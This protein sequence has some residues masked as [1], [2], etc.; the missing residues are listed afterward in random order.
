M[1]RRRGPDMSRAS[2]TWPLWS[3]E[4]TLVVT[5]PAKLDPAR[6]IADDLFRS[7]DQAAS[8]FRGDSELTTI[9]PELPHGVAVS[10]TLAMLV[11]AALDAARATG[12]DVDPTLGRA[13]SAVGYD[14]D[15]RLIIEDDRIV[16]AISAER[17]GWR[18]VLLAGLA[19]RVPGHLALDL[20]A[21]AK[22]VA[23]DLAAQAIA[24]R[25]HTGVL[26]SIG[27]DLA[28]AGES[29][30]WNVL[31][32]DLPDDP[33]ARV[34]LAPGWAMATSSTQKRSWTVAG[35]R[36]HHILDPRTGLPADPVWR[37]V[38]VTAPDCVTANTFSTAAMV[39]GAGA[40]AM[41]AERA[42]PAR[43]VDAHGVVHALN[44]WPD[45][46]RSAA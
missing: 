6:D 21:T 1:R 17:P 14:R 43:L 31:V 8:R 2:V 19:L 11:R 12:G 15:I 28:T 41:L 9:G 30:A 40:I 16:R 18:S 45:E 22:A 39:R 35:T 10:V 38:T 27:G 26:V 3:T 46:A 29:A 13:L 34:A 37:T 42:L 23:A 24:S 32:Q 44:G 20:G 7:I 5:E 33:A 4:A 36:Y 25:L